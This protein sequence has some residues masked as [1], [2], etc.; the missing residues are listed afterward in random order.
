MQTLKST[1]N[2]F[3]NNHNG[4]TIKDVILKRY[5]RIYFDPI[6]RIRFEVQELISNIYK[7]DCT[8]D[9]IK[10]LIK[11]TYYSKRW[12]VLYHGISQMISDLKEFDPDIKEERSKE[13][14]SLTAYLA[15]SN[16]DESKNFFKN[17]KLVSEL[18]A[19]YKEHHVDKSFLMILNKV[20]NK[21]LT[22]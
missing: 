1:Q 3:K 18:I 10:E 20:F 7:H 6:D 5:T 14:L 12:N 19:I 11:R 21:D 2:Y 17:K 13:L 4:D 16:H 9:Q 8:T 22:N 15:F